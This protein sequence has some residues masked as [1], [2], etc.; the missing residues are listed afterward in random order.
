M[1]AHRGH[2]SPV[3]RTVR[4]YRRDTG[5]FL[6]ETTSSGVGGHFYLE[7]SYS[8]AQYVVCVDDDTGLDY[9]AL[10]YDSIMPTTISGG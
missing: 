10:I 8:G 6:N 5:A 7:T 3:E 4:S 1:T 9:N 2:S